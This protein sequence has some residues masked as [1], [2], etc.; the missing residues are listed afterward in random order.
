MGSVQSTLAIAG[1][2]AVGSAAV[3]Y[4]YGQPESTSKPPGPPTEQSKSTK[5]KKRTTNA[6][7]DIDEILAA[8]AAL[9]KS[10]AAAVKPHVV[11]FPE[12]VP[13]GFAPE[14][15]STP[16]PETGSKD[17]R[18]KKKKKKSTAAVPVSQSEDASSSADDPNASSTNLIPEPSSTSK[19]KK[20]DRAKK[21]SATQEP[22][23][24]GSSTRGSAIRQTA[25]DEA[26]D[27]G[28]W[29][30]V[31]SRKRTQGSS[32][33]QGEQIVSDAGITTSVTETSSVATE[34]TDDEED[35]NAVTPSENR[36]TFAEKMLPKP[37]KTGV[38]E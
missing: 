6:D 14:K 3:Y 2:V 37:R 16:K 13:G 26:L 15:E 8:Q 24:T 9:Q 7:E 10:S 1:L 27:D 36:K 32:V 21:S 30:R 25:L 12:I 33:N 35:T 20:K 31:E 29:T 18:A 4:F 19:K 34:R 5:S 28:P 17:K 23:G 22:S 38:E 11:E